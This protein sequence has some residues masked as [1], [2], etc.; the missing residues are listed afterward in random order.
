MILRNLKPHSQ[1]FSEYTELRVQENRNT[2][3]TMVNGDL[4]NNV[5]TAIGGVSARV[6]KN[7]R[8]GFASSPHVTNEGIKS[9]IQSSTNNAN[10]LASR[11]RA[12]SETGIPETLASYEMNLATKASK[13]S[14]KFW[15]DYLK[16]IDD[17]ILQK[18]SQVT[19]R[20]IV[21]IGLD[22]EKSLLTATGSESYSMTPRSN[23]ILELSV[24]KDGEPTTLL[25][26]HGG[27]GELEDRFDEPASLFKKIDQQVEHL[28]K[29]A[30]GIY[31]EAGE[32]Q[33]ILDADL[34]GILAHEAIGHTT[35]GDIVMGGSIAGEY[36]DQLV[37]TPLVTLVDFANTF[38]GDLCP[39]P[40]YV[41]DEGTACQ[42]TVVIENGVLKSYM[43]NKDTARHFEA[44]PTGNARAYQFSDEPLVRMR[45]TAILPGKDKLADMIASVENG[46]YLIK[47]S[48][49]QADTNSEFMFGITLGYEIK[50]GKLGKAIKDTTIS[51][52][53]FDVL[54]TIDMISDDMSW[55]SG[56]M[57]GKKQ[58]IPVGMGG[59]AV[60]CKINI[61]G[62]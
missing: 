29:K 27:R 62:R 13:N 28:Q 9:V 1:L 47:H 23:L 61:G 4:V 43:H 31:P 34:A 3:L 45:N 52:V 24:E 10:F 51:G 22:M 58:L 7:G 35:E 12:K 39:V 60:K 54:K 25:I 33:V 11:N 16:V 46:Y 18:H 2:R 48:N 59:P 55:A 8:W 14:N 49:G 42:D 50:N 57:C 17:Y 36:M 44:E 15:L 5:S 32:Q 6:F 20:T 21:L 56:G 41:D 37:A 19:T 53:A 40:L 26:V 38:N 30:W